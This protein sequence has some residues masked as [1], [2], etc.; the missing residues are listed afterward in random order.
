MLISID[1][2][3]YKI[4][5]YIRTYIRRKERMEKVQKKKMGRPLTANS[6][7][8]KTLTI[9]VNDEQRNALKELAKKKGLTVSELILKTFK[10]IK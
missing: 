7:R 1:L 3:K 8:D 10:L 9:R 6:T 2:R 4:Y 5:Y